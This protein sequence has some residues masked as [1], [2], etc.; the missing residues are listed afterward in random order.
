LDLKQRKKSIV[1]IVTIIVVSAA[2]IIYSQQI[3]GL[4]R[5]E[6]ADRILLIVLILATVV[7]PLLLYWLDRRKLPKLVFERPYHKYKDLT[8]NITYVIRVKN[9][10]KNSEGRVENC[11]GLVE[12]RGTDIKNKLSLWNDNNDVDIMF[13]DYADLRLF[14]TKGTEE[15]FFYNAKSGYLNLR[16]YQEYI[17]KEITIRVETQRGLPPIPLTERIENIMNETQEQID[18]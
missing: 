17:H 13:A 4:L 14:T 11:S 3:Y 2:I 5:P 7:T 18:N 1:L 8:G 9:S 16:P 6:V 10:N 12:I 15:I